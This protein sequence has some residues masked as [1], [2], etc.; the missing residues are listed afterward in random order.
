[1]R[2]LLRTGMKGRLLLALALSLFA[3]IASAAER[4][5]IILI[6][7][8]DLGYE[9]VSAYGSLTFKT[10]NLDALAGGGMLFNHC[11]SQP[12]CTPSRVQIMTG[13]Y[14]FRNYTRFGHLSTGETTF[15]NLLERQGYATVIAGK[16]QLEGDA[17]TVRQFGF[18]THC[19]WHI[20]GR[21]S[22]YWDPRVVENGQVRTD[23]AG[24]FGPDVMC[25]FIV[26]FIGRKRD[27][28]FL[29]YYPML[30]PHWPF[31]PTPE[32]PTGGSRER[33]AKYD[34]RAGG[35]E[36]FPDMV[37]H[38]DKNIGRIVVA[39]DKQGV[40]ENTLILFTCDNGCAINITSKMPSRTIHGGKGS[41]PDAGT[42]VAL[43]ASWPA[44][45]SPGQVSDQ[46]VDFTDMLPT[47][48]A[49][50][51]A[52]QPE[53]TQI[54]G[55]S[56]LGTLKNKPG[57]SRDWVFC[58]YVRNGIRKAPKDAA[59][60]KQVLAKQRKARQAKTMGR[61]ARNQRFK[62][63]DDGRFYDVSRDPLE[64]QPITADAAASDAK[65]AHAML[66][67]VHKQMPPWQAFK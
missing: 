54:D 56:F 25:D 48:A 4:P 18:Q 60:R 51:G 31:V 66:D 11:Y 40:R 34:G 20:G 61:Y 22:R 59:K 17:N 55:L 52:P 44:A 2:L 10:P 41:L 15:A 49:A 13:R 57:K 63:Y 9:G 8:D 33:L 27:K 26:N 30:L 64:K 45:I 1:M 14:N 3:N 35:T 12:I 38:I 28:P 50:G 21:E 46:L 43:V 23:T 65:V 24:R 16:W 19:L 58:H 6:M 62:L 36:Y 47:V 39:L 5:N 37:A 29:V 67:Q 53:N 7:A 32:S 42:H